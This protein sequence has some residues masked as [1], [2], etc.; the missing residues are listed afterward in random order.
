MTTSELDELICNAESGKPDALIEAC[1]YLLN[2]YTALRTNNLVQSCHIQLLKLNWSVIQKLAPE[3]LLSEPSIKGRFIEAKSAPTLPKIKDLFQFVILTVQN[4]SINTE[5]LQRLSVV[6]NRFGT[7]LP[8]IIDCHFKEYSNHS[9]IKNILSK[10]KREPSFHSYVSLIKDILSLSIKIDEN[11]RVNRYFSNIL[12]NWREIELSTDATSLIPRCQKLAQTLGREN[13]LQFAK[14]RY[15]A[16]NGIATD[17][18]GLGIMYE[19][20]IGIHQDD[21]MAK[22][23]YMQAINAGYNDA[24][25]YLDNLNHRLQQQKAQETERLRIQTQLE[26]QKMEQDLRQH[27]AENRARLESERLEEERRHNKQ[28]E[29]IELQKIEA[30][31]EQQIW[32]EAERERQAKDEI[33]EVIFYYTLHRWNEDIVRGDK[34]SKITKSEYNSLL[35]GGKQAIIS[36]VTGLIG[37]MRDG[38]YIIDASMKKL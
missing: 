14:T 6:F 9:D 2:D 3:V 36:Y 15:R 32:E 10:Y 24:Q 35:T 21:S 18:A 37:Y 16:E 20:G 33:V 4:L 38:E 12:M 29:D 34:I 25:L 27:E 7:L 22:M 28:M 5:Y 19:Q 17:I 30:E 26:I 13:E 8:A 1:E 11:A 23:L 31:R